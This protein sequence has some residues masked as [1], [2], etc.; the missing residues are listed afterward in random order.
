[1]VAGNRKILKDIASM[2]V[3]RGTF[4]LTM[5]G[6]GGKILGFLYRI[7]LTR[8]VGSDGLGLYQVVLP[9]SGIIFSICCVGFQASVSRFVAKDTKNSLSWFIAALS[10]SL[11]AALA[12]TCITYTHAGFIASDILL[13]NEA[14]DCVA[15]LAFSFPFLAIHDCCCGYFYGK[16]STVIPAISQL[17]EQAL[18]ILVLWLC[19]S[20]M[21]AKGKSVT[22]G[23]AIISNIIGDAIACAYILYFLHRKENNQLNKTNH[24][25]TNN[26]IHRLTNSL[27]IT[28]FKSTLAYAIPINVNSL[29]VHLFT[30]AEAVLI[31]A[32]LIVSGYSASDALKFYGILSGMVLPLIMLPSV[33][34][35]SLSV[36]LLPVVAQESSHT[37]RTVSCVLKLCL[38]FG[39]LSTAV[40]YCIL[41]DIG[42]II[43]AEPLVKDFTRLLSWLC[44]FM[45]LSATMNS[46]LN[47]TGKTTAT[48]LMNT[49]GILV[50][51]CALIAFVPV[52][53]LIPYLYAI[54]LSRVM[55]CIMQLIYLH[56]SHPV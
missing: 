26:L 17:I 37:H 18:R 4:I 16:K 48:C 56:T 14:E 28:Y 40:Y 32:Q 24:P 53:G 30:S 51:L 15:L 6:M 5:A 29:L 2:P 50:R 45:Y 10:I 19:F 35:N 31:P 21:T 9:L 12:A 25:E 52:H 49:I 23:C 55:I 13:Q 38:L 39:V 41:G 7:L 46:I 8:A 44:P 22:P 20:Y 34:T 42:A 36:M 47:G 43:F 27:N 54:L 33:L 1:M 11:P 3:V